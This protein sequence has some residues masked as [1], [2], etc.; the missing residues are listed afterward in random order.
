MHTRTVPEWWAAWCLRRWVG[1]QWLP[2]REAGLWLA[3]HEMA[4]M[5]EDGY[6]HPTDAGRAFLRR[7]PEPEHEP[8]P[9]FSP[10][11]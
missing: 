4:W 6:V 1:E 9:S 11:A 3:R 2:D 10:A 8:W 7:N 5:D